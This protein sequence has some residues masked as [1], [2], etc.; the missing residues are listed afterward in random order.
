MSPGT[1]QRQLDSLV[2]EF[3]RAY[4]DHDFMAL[5]RMSHMDSDRL[6]YLDTVFGK[7]RSIKVRLGTLTVKEK[8]QEASATIIHDILI[9]NNGDTVV[10]SPI[11]KSFRIKILK[12]GDQWTKI[13]W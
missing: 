6:T 12:A 4:E 10:P 13:E 2:R 3:M 1:S 9:D 8:E 5:K 11:H 7:Y